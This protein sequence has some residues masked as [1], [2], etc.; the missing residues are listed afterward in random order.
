MTDQ[1]RELVSLMI[2]YRIR[3]SRRSKALSQG[4]L[5]QGIGSQSMISLLE[6]GR[7]LPLPDVLLLIAER[8]ADELLVRYA[9]LLE[10]GAWSLSD[11][12]SSNQDILLEVLLAHRGKWQDVHA[13]LA[14]ELC[15]VFY[16]NRIFR[17]VSEICLL[18]LNHSNDGN[19][20][21]Q[22]LFYLGST[23][24][25]LH[26]Y[27]E[28][29]HWLL[30]AE[31]RQQT[32]DDRLRSRLAYN[33][34]YAY[35]MLEHYGLGMWY[36]KVAV[37]EF[38]RTHEYARHAKAL[39]LLGVIQCRLG[40]YGEAKD[41]L[42][43]ASELFDKWEIR[44]P[45]RARIDISL[46]D[47]HESLGQYDAAED[48]CQ[49][50]IQSSQLAPDYVTLSAA[51]RIRAIVLRH[52][53]ADHATVQEAIE[54]AITAAKRSAD[55]RSLSHCH[56]LAAEILVTHDEKLTA[57]RAAYDEAVMAS[58]AIL[59]ALAAELIANLERERDPKLAQEF[60]YL[61]VAAYHEY[62]AN[63]SRFSTEF[64]HLSKTPCL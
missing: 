56:L 30:E 42:T 7:Q 55:G 57:A 32:L 54:S 47:V 25:F 14:V 12:T 9:A 16:D 43:V 10:A 52:R 38:Q 39:G 40:H 28:A 49:R 61:S 35:T 18:I 29:M 17:K 50:A 31:K 5:A 64:L 51:Y 1:E 33:L 48:W 24:L 27:E 19:Y 53:L 8:L 44:G 15:T 11:F 6:S 60:L 62:L 59:R 20:R 2:G 26:H 21:T 46:A 36:A 37:D 58:C 63:N 34:G 3:S 4:E 13:K 45:D 41:T 23:E 22:A